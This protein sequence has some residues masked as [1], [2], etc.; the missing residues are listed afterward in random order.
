MKRKIYKNH[1][2]IGKAQKMIEQLQWFIEE[3]AKNQ[4]IPDTKFEYMIQIPDGLLFSIQDLN[5]K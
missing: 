5:D 2:A 4:F 1:Q 3:C